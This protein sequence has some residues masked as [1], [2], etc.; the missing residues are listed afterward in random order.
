MDGTFN[1][2]L[3]TIDDLLHV[4]LK[5]VVCLVIIVLGALIIKD[6]IFTRFI[7]WV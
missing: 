2:T 7:K 3:F 4:N 1:A 5:I 6:F